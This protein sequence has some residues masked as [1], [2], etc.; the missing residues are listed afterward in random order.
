[1][2]QT[3]LEAA[4]LELAHLTSRT[5]TTTLQDRADVHVLLDRGLLKAV[6]VGEDAA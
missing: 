3:A 4:A 5:I 6:T 2:I 1:M